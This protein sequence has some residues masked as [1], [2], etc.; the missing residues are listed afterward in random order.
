MY[1]NYDYKDSISKIKSALFDI[2]ENQEIIVGN[3]EDEEI[4]NVHVEKYIDLKNS[5]IMLIDKIDKLYQEDEYQIDNN[6]DNQSVDE[7]KEITL[8][9]K[10]EENVQEEPKIISNIEIDSEEENNIDENNEEETE[11]NIDENDEEEVEN[12]EVSNEENPETDDEEQTEE[13]IDVDEEKNEDIPKFYLDDRNGNKPNFAY[14]PENLYQILKNNN[15]NNNDEEETE[16]ENI[17]NKFYKDSDDKVKGIIVRNDQFMKL[18]LSCHRQ[19]GVIKEAKEYRI[20]QAK[21]SRQKFQ[22]ESLKKGK[23]EL[24]I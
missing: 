20:M 4:R 6:K 16:V 17:D 13:N 11:D 19:E 12:T 22:E 3:I 2:Y 7:S 21:K 24:N 14:V 5:A 1:N 15:K 18:S 10:P 8:E 9:K 23:V